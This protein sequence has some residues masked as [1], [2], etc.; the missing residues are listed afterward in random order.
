MAFYNNMYHG[1]HS[2]QFI[3]NKPEDLDKPLWL[4]GYVVTKYNLL[5]N[6]L[7]YSQFF[8]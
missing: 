3:S 8:I 7:S 4:T 6:G 5:C 2:C 1:V